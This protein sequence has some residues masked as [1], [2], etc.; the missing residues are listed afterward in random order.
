MRFRLRTQAMPYRR[1]RTCATA[2]APAYI[3]D[4]RHAQREAR[5]AQL[6]NGPRR[7]RPVVLVGLMGAGKSTVGRRLA[8][9]LG[10]DFMDAD[11]AIEEAAGM[12]IPEIFERYGEPAFRD[13]ERRVVLRLLREGHGVIALGGGAFVDPEI[14]RAV[15][16]QAVSVWLR[17]DLDTLVERTARRPG[18]RPLLM[19]GDPREI[20]AE[21]MERRHPIYAE[22][23]ITVDTGPGPVDRVVEAVLA[24]LCAADAETGR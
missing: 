6:R 22:A 17:A 1:T 14:R 16:E 3:P 7:D 5:R 11:D 19:R 18:R 9:A 10:T 20:L 23:D 4:A 2:A 8:A 12:S 21:L 24:H 13:L 15:R